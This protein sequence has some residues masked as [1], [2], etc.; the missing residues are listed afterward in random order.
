MFELRIY[1]VVNS[2]ISNWIL[3][4]FGFSRYTFPRDDGLNGHNVCVFTSFA[5]SDIGAESGSVGQD[6]LNSFTEISLIS[7]SLLY[8]KR[9]FFYQQFVHK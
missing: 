5:N 9:L 6:H 7:H 8:W 3:S 2:I 1:K 4:E